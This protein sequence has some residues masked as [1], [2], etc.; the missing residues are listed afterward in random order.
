MFKPAKIKLKGK[1]N[2][3]ILWDDN[4]ESLIRLDK[5]RFYC[6]CNTCCK[7]RFRRSPYYIPIYTEN[8]ITPKSLTKV[9]NSAIRIEWNDGHV[10]G[11][12]GFS[13]LRK[14]YLK[15]AAK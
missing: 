1:R 11:S 8:Q 9:D 15:K 14:L 10:T 4:F 3:F 12:F 2:L 5:I 7:D 6:P 13:F